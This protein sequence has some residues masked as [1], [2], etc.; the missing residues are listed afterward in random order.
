MAVFREDRFLRNYETQ[1]NGVD[2]PVDVLLSLY[3]FEYEGEQA[4]SGGSWTSPCAR[5]WKERRAHQ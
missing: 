5:P 2:K 1:L 3:E 4:I